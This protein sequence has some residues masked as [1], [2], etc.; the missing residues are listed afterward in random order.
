MLAAMPAE[1][2]RT[3]DM[4]RLALSLVSHEKPAPD[5]LKTYFESVLSQ[6]R[7][8]RENPNSAEGPLMPEAIQLAVELDA[9]DDFRAAVDQITELDSV[10]AEQ[11]GRILGSLER[12][13]AA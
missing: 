11:A 13:I 4:F 2:T 7:A 3:L 8:L 9:W 5:Q 6:A 10:T 12:H 1:D